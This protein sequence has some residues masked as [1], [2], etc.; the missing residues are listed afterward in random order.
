MTHTIAVEGADIN[1]TCH[2]GETILVAAERAGYTMPYSCRKGVCASCEGFLSKGDVKQRSK[3]MTGPAGKVLFCTATAKSDL[4]IR[5]RRIQRHDPLARKKIQ[6]RVFRMSR[7]V[8][9]VAILQLRFPASIRAKF[10]AG[11]Y[12]RIRMPDGDE[13]SFS[14]AN[15]PQESDC[16]QLHIRH[17]PGGAFSERVLA[18]LE[19]DDKLEVEVPFGDF[20]LREDDQARYVFVAT[21]TGFAPLKSMLDD[22]IRRRLNRE[23]RFYWGGR[24]AADLYLAETCEKWAKRYPWFTFIPVLSEAD[25]N[26]AGR[27]GLVHVA[28]LE[29]LIDLSDRHVYACGNPMMI[30]AARNEF[31]TRCGLPSDRFYADA[32]IPSGSSHPTLVQVLQAAG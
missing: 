27:R 12:L 23:V 24:T 21:G 32:F 8:D 11:Q 3:E 28:V 25:P 5:A 14:M 4:T 29:D 19:L 13:R 30:E 9:D 10:K 31:T 1:F 6:A 2:D 22:M 26:W 15:A 16:V 20:Y 7:P 17:V 18:S